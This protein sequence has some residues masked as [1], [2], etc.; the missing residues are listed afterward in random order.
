MH[1][2][3]INDDEV[4]LF[5]SAADVTVLPYKS[6]TQSGIAQIAMYYELPLIVTQKGGL[7]ELIEHGKTGLLLEN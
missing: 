4:P 7:P 3:Y 1:I 2:R 6:A 5:F